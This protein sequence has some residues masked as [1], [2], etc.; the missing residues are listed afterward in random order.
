MFIKRKISQ[1]RRKLRFVFACYTDEPTAKDCYVSSW[2]PYVEK[3]VQ[4]MKTFQNS[5]PKIKGS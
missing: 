5:I 1:R 3:S 4:I 2:D